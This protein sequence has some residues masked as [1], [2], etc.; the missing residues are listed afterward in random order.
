MC[1]YS[2]PVFLM[3]CERY[4][5]FFS[6]KLPFVSLLVTLFI[7][8]T[9]H[10]IRNNF[11]VGGFIM[12]HSSKGNIFHESANTMARQYGQMLAISCSKSSTNASK[13]G[14]EEHSHH[15]VWMVS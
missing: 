5:F 15:H 3:N 8:V 1:L 7:A 14:K 9:K 11:S 13:R 12:S 4:I 6:F 2:G 10:L